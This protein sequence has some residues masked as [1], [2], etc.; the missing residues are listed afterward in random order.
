VEENGKPTSSSLASRPPLG[1]FPAKVD[2]KGRMKLPTVFQQHFNNADEGKLFITS[3]DGRIGRIYSISAWRDNEALFE[4]YREDPDAL[5]NLLFN[6]QDLG[7]EAK[8]DEQGRVTLNTELRK[9][10]KLAAGQE[11]HLYAYKNCVEFL[12]DELYQEKRRKA[13]PNAEQNVRKLE[14][15]GMK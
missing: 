4:Q 9:E 1:M 11:L 6:A 13:R 2:D 5:Q 14:S 10:L 3:L 12:T 8:I 7:A 15:A